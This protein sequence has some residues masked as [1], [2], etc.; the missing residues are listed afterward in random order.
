MRYNLDQIRVTTDGDVQWISF[1]NLHCLGC[2]TR[3]L[4]GL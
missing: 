4:E 3:S 1:P 2:E